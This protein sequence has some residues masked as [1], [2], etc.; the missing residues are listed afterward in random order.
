MARVIEAFRGTE[1]SREA[2]VAARWCTA[3]ALPCSLAPRA[4][5][6]SPSAVSVGPIRDPDSD[7]IKLKTRGVILTL[8]GL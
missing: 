4:A 3:K 2:T 8:I 6:N 5:S 7:D 1:K